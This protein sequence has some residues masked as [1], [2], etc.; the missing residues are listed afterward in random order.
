MDKIESRYKE[1]KKRLEI[2]RKEM[3]E[4]EQTFKEKETEMLK[5]IDLQKFELRMIENILD[6]A[7][8]ET[9]RIRRIERLEK[10]LKKE[11]IQKVTLHGQF[12][13]FTHSAKL[14]FNY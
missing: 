7:S 12:C 8:F 3:E 13:I 1:T 5:E 14:K 4:T 11:L 10:S 6:F 2:L 9:I